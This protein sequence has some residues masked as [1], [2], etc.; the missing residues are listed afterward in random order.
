MKDALINRFNDVLSPKANELFKAVIDYAESIDD[1]RSEIELKFPNL[2]DSLKIEKPIEKLGDKKWPLNF[3]HFLKKCAAMYFGEIGDT[4]QLTLHDGFSGT[5]HSIGEDIV[6]PKRFGIAY[7]E[8][9]FSPIDDGLNTFYFFHP[10]TNKLCLCD[11]GPIQEVT[12]TSDSVEI[13]LR[14]LHC[15]LKDTAM[16][17]NN[18]FMEAKHRSSWLKDWQP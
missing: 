15:L 8:E 5:L 3:D 1:N 2:E 18:P 11:E 9:I 17:D 16:D 13:F 10:I 7:S 12:D 4:S 14:E 6:N